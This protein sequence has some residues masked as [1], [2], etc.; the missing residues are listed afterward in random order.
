MKRHLDYLLNNNR[1]INILC[2]L[3]FIFIF[4]IVLFQVFR[5]YTIESFENT[6]INP[7]IEIAKETSY[8]DNLKKEKKELE[9]TNTDLKEKNNEMKDNINKLN[10]E[11][12]EKKK[13]KLMLESKLSDI[14]KERDL[15]LSIA[16]LVKISI[17]KTLQKEQELI[18]KK[19]E[20]NIEKEK[21][22]Q[23]ED[24]KQLTDILN[25]LKEVKKNTEQPEDFCLI[26]KEIPKV[27]FKTYK[28]SEKDL[29]LEWCKCSE[30][31]DKESCT[32]YKSC[33]TNYDKYKDVKS[34]GG[35]DLMLYFNCLKIYPEFPKYLIDN[36]NDKK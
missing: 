32:N 9:K 30:N 4:I 3:F 21:E 25:I 35:E 24:N 16:E 33:K 8:L 17:D 1:M 31:K 23:K 36:N 20:I 14:Y 12:E 34:L 29:V 7:V 26:T 22:M 11:F 15:N 13:E 6:E 27:E 28:D 2:I 18:K 10:K 5:I 19:D